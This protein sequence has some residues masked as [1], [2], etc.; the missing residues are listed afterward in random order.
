MHT[1]TFGTCSSSLRRAVVPSLVVVSVVDHDHIFNRRHSANRM[2][3][4]SQGAKRL[5]A[6]QAAEADAALTTAY[7]IPVS[8]QQ[9][10]RNQSQL[11]NPRLS[12][13]WS[14]HAK[15]NT[16]QTAYR[17]R[18]LQP[19]YT[20][21]E[22]ERGKIPVRQRLILP[23]IG[24]RGRLP[25]CSFARAQQSRARIIVSSPHAPHSVIR[26]QHL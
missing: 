5:V 6:K 9:A 17:R 22:V 3:Q 1:F 8:Y 25:S 23:V 15:S 26:S 10:D 11:S 16:M 21:H 12:I 19:T 7:S 24:P 18:R 13:H 2:I 14:S 4:T 20:R